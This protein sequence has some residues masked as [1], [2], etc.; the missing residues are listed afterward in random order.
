MRAKPAGSKFE[1]W[2]RKLPPNAMEFNRPV[3]TPEL[4]TAS[5]MLE[6]ELTRVLGNGSVDP[7][8]RAITL[9]VFGSV[10]TTEKVGDR[11]LP[12]RVPAM[13]APPTV[14]LKLPLADP[15]CVAVNTI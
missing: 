2:T 10:Y 13:V 8:C 4:M 15:A 1:N 6:V 5:E 12:A 3:P 9:L 11:V 14:K 7:S